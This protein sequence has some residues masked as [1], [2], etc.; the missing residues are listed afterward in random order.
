MQGEQ[1]AR[2]VVSHAG[3]A[4]ASTRRAML[5]DRE[6]SAGA[7]DRAAG[8]ARSAL[9]RCAARLGAARS[10][11]ARA[12]L[13]RALAGARLDE[14]EIVELF[15]RRRRGLH[16][17][18]ACRRRVA[19]RR[20]SATR[21]LTSSTA[22]STTRTS[23]VTRAASARLRKAAVRDRCA[24]RATRSTSH[25]IAQRVTRSRRAWRDRSL[26]ARR[27]PSELHRSHLPRYRRRG[28]GAVPGHPRARVLAARS[29]SRREHARACRWRTTCEQLQQR[30]PAHVARNR[31]R[32][33]LRRRPRDDLSRT[34][35]TTAEWLAGHAHGASHR[36]AQHGDDHVRPRRASRALGAAP[37]RD[38][39][40]AGRD[41]RLHRVRAAAVRAH[42][43][44]ALAPRVSALAD[45]A[46]AR[47]S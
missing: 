7:G 34:S 20:P 37:A 35:S 8:A 11:V 21:S 9:I 29:Q 30:G 10:S 25:E 13:Q 38:A 6:W 46:S 41:R 2:R 26:P 23:A 17:G 43:G 12:P 24:G 40:P 16:R 14:R 15:A 32:D 1:L 5:K 33:S 39:R 47:R 36:T 44:A 28:V 3:A 22:T 18:R 27:H 31:R 42:G 4:R 19:R 45:R